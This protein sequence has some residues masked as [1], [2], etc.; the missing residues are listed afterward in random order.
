[1]NNN[2]F[3]Y[4]K[5]NLDNKIND[6]NKIL[7]ILIKQILLF[8]YFIYLMWRTKNSKKEIIIYNL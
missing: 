2:N 8:H 6:E 1:M 3:L 7:E 4:G 5:E